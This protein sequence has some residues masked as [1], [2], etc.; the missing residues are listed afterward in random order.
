MKNQ[1]YIISF[2]WSTVS[3]LFNAVFGFISVPL[4][5]HYFG[6]EN[7]GILTIAFASNAYMQLMD[8]GI[9]NGSIKFFSEWKAQGKF[10]LIERVARTSLS[11][12]LI[13]GLINSLLLISL[14][15]WGEHLFAVSIEQFKVLRTI[16]FII[17][18]TSPIS[19]VS[20]VFSQLLTANKLIVF[21]Q[22]IELILTAIKF[23]LILCTIYSKGYITLIVYFAF[24]STTYVFNT[25][26][27]Y[28][29][30]KKEKLIQG[31]IPK[32]YWTD[33][34]LVLSYSLALFALSLF[35][36]TAT[37]SRPIILSIFANNAAKTV[38][39]YKI[40]EVFPMFIIS[41]AG[42]LTMIFLPRSAEL[43]ATNNIEG[44]EKMAYEGT[45][46]T[47]LI[48]VILTF[49]ILLNIPEL[50]QLYVGVEYLYLAKWVYIMCFT[51]L[52]FIHSTP[53]NSLLLATG[54]TKEYVYSTIVS[55]VISILINIFLCKKIGVGA[56]IMGY[57]VYIVLQMSFQYIYVYKYMLGLNP[58]KVLK[59]FL[60]PVVYCVVP[61]IV[62]FFVFQHLPVTLFGAS[63]ISILLFVIIKCILL[64]SGVLLVLA[65]K[66][67]IDIRN[68]YELIMNKVQSKI[69]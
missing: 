66:K 1:Y 65:Y 32:G 9:S 50:L 15:I 64:F 47:A 20:G 14:G 27:F 56:S 24:I 40:V 29:K 48:S 30:C 59:S 67:V 44:K 23:I 53:C 35:Q 58:L 34:K 10:D 68:I 43:I 46:Y 36:M 38:A 12:Y 63:K 61:F 39:E 45:F 41:I 11:F 18:F 51:V 21:N 33:F 42:I 37:Q 28:R 57:F 6:I 52:I 60:L 55:C 62:V 8:L 13:I 31:F 26:I 5:L 54:R 16:F 19:W 2:L 22:K 7:Y 4:L 3:K 17:A 49:P 69:R 25:F